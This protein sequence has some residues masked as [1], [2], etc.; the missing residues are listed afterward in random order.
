[1]SAQKT[2]LITFVRYARNDGYAPNY[3]LRLNLS[4]DVLIRQAE[5]YQVPI[6]ILIVE[7]NPPADRPP[8]RHILDTPTA[9]DYATIRIITVP[10]EFHRG[11]KGASAKGLHP[12]R[13]LNVGYRRAHGTFV[14]PFAS[15]SLLSDTVFEYA[16]Q[17]G[18]DERHIYRLDR[19]DIDPEF[20]EKAQRGTE[21]PSELFELCETYIVNQLS[22]QD[23]T[24]SDPL[25]LPRLHTNAAGDFLLMSR[26]RWH[27]LQG[28]PE[29]C[30]VSCLDTDSITLHAAATYG[31]Q[32]IRLPE[33]CRLYKIIHG[34]VNRLRV[35]PIWNLWS[36]SLSALIRRFSA[37]TATRAYLRGLVDIPRRSMAGMPGSYVSFEKNFYLK[38]R[39]W[40]R[41]KTEIQLNDDNWGLGNTELHEQIL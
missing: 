11:F 12:A 32:E 24:L 1:M 35:Q 4:N 3:E 15:D 31:G 7:W 33:S 13:A 19:F 16:V 39:R 6:E 27:R 25:E 30:D 38:A 14:T 5:Q 28:Q 8:L 21:N 36:R 18:F 40:H 9:S 34:K 29:N 2:P 23:E 22:A 10:P 26:S 20:L 41:D 37:S 17:K